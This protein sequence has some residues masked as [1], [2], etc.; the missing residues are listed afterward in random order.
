MF[1]QFEIH[2]CNKSSGSLERKVLAPPNTPKS[3]TKG[4]EQSLA[5]SQLAQ[6]EKDQLLRQSEDEGLAMGKVSNLNDE[7]RLAIAKS[8]E[9][10][11]NFIEVF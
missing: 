6:L 2:L 5:V 11:R 9:D 3:P 7:N 4:K 8:L 1:Q 10:I